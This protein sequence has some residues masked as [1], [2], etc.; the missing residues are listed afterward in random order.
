MK[1]FQSK[2]SRTRNAVEDALGVRTRGAGL[3]S[4]AHTNGGASHKQLVTSATSITETIVS[5]NWSLIG[6]D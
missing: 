6:D 5:S 2:C 3:D 4:A 1:T